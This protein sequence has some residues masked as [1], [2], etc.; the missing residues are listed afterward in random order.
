[1]TESSDIV[2]P[3]EQ[4]GPYQVLRGFRGRGG[5]ARIYEAEVR[6][7]YWRPGMPRRLV[8]KVADEAHQSALVA[9]ADYLSRFNHPNVVHIFPLPGYHRPVYAAKER[10]TFGWRW[11]YA[12]ELLEGGSLEFTLTRPSR[13]TDAFRTPATS[14]RPLALVM[15]LGIARQLVDALSHIHACS[16]LNLDIKPGN[17]LFRRQRLGSLRS[18]VPRAVLS[19]FGIARDKRIPR[20]GELGVATPEYVSPEHAIEIHGGYATLDERSD[21]F[22]LGVV[23]YEM[24]TGQ[25]PFENIGLIM[26]PVYSPVPPG[27]LRPG[28]P[29]MLEQVILRALSKDPDERY[30]SALALRQALDDV[31]TFVD[32]GMIAR[33]VFLGVTLTAAAAFGGH[34]L[35]D[36]EQPSIPTP[37]TVMPKSSA[38]SPATSP[39]T[40]PS[41]SLPSQEGG[42]VSTSTPR[43]T[44]TPTLTPKPI[45]PTATPSLQSD[46]G[47]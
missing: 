40:L 35:F 12:M 34:K 22:S 42:K 18:S 43:P 10:F 46:L 3:G 14:E 2:E 47:G 44:F 26:S 24:L 30:Q 19:D 32:W 11:Y 5:M 37:Q 41:P 31:G 15:V 20:F 29:P 9:E 17:I 28:I 45:T 25:L 4:I 8:L 33:R 21:I 39:A 23:L 38:T 7:K 36:S 27:Q 13:I 6:E 16:V 1:M